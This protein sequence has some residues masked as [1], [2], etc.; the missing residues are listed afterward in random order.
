MDAVNY[1]DFR[2]NL[3]NYFDKAVRNHEPL[4]VTRKTDN[5]VIMSL[6][7]YNSIM[8]T[9]YLLKNRANAKNLMESI[10]QL[11]SRNSVI[12]TIEELEGCE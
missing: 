5:M 1:S 7:D 8:E 2:K 10:E 12:K 3:K 6:E 11:E 4:I 9:N